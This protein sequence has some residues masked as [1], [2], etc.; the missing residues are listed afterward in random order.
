MMVET[1]KTFAAAITPVEQAFIVNICQEQKSDPIV[2]QLESFKDLKDGWDFGGGEAIAP[3]AITKA[4]QLYN[5]VKVTY[6]FDTEVHPLSSGGV[7]VLFFVDD[8]FL[9]IFIQPDTSMDLV[10]EK[11]IGANYEQL[12]EEED[13]DM[14]TLK[15]RFNNL[16]ASKKTS[17]LSFVPC[18]LKNTAQ[19]RN[20]LHQ[21]S[22]PTMGAE[23][24]YSITNVPR[25]PVKVYASTLNT[26]TT[27]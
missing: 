10:E 24:L 22:F 17:W 11:G 19:Q 27:R 15:Q 18:I 20:D 8:Y 4:I 13:V 12:Y 23:F 16:L 2:K 3:L 9:D 7:N 5:L 14:D 6:Q 25:Q 26:F 1:V 21:I